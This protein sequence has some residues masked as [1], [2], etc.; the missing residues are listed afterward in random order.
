[1]GGFFSSLFSHPAPRAIRAAPLPAT[2]AMGPGRPSS[3]SQVSQV[4]PAWQSTPSPPSSG[5]LS[6]PPAAACCTLQSARCTAC[7]LG[8]TVDAYC[9]DRGASPGCTVFPALVGGDIFRLEVD[10]TPAPD[11]RRVLGYTQYTQ[12]WSLFT[13]PVPHYGTTGQ[14]IQARGDGTSSGPWGSIEG[15]LVVAD[16]YG[17]ARYHVAA[18]SHRYNNRSDTL[19]GF[20]FHEGAL[21]FRYWARVVMSSRVLLP[22][23]GV[24]F[25][26]QDEG[27]LFGAGWIAMPLFDFPSAASVGAVDIAGKDPLT[28]TFFADAANFSGPVCCYPPHFFARRIPEWAALRRGENPAL[29]QE[30]TRANVG[31]SLAFNGPSRA[32]GIEFGLT[33]GG[34]IGNIPCAFATDD[35]DGSMVWKVPEM[36]IPAAGST[37]LSDPSYYTEKNFNSVKAQ[38]SLSS[39]SANDV[40]LVPTA[41]SLLKRQGPHGIRA[42]VK[43]VVEPGVTEI[44]SAL[45]ID[46]YVRA[47]GDGEAYVVGGTDAGRTLGRYFAQTNELQERV[48]N[49]TGKEVNRNYSV[50]AG[51]AAVGNTLIARSEHRPDLPVAMRND[52][53]REYVRS[54]SLDGIRETRIE[55]G[56]VVYYGIVRFVD[57]PALASLAQDFPVDFAPDKLAQVQAKFERL[58]STTSF[59]AQMRRTAR[60]KAPGALVHIDPGLLIADVPRGYVPV[61]VGSTPRGQSAP[62][63]PMYSE[64][65]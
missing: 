34:E 15:G 57:Q 25:R 6:V 55:D 22:P 52:A 29:P 18:S 2:G 14:W 11:A 20:G 53:L 65:W 40:A 24:C 48:V 46:A 64:T 43:R 36:R 13:L 39:G 10:F 23:H 38:L 30:Y 3:S 49:G 37:W 5:P 60:T 51:P 32:E 7:S 44:D 42:F 63:P 17:G 54:K 61:A 26:A 50:P 58:A 47:S 1:M 9:A 27:K 4:S 41:A 21:P 8:T 16:K 35:L 59:A 62:A 45:K 56:T 12:L 33:V 19:G 28:W 31:G